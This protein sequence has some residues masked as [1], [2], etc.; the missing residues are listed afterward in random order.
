MFTSIDKVD[1][2][3]WIEAIESS[4]KLEP[5]PALLQASGGSVV[6][7]G[8]LSCHKFP[9]ESDNI[10]PLQSMSQIKLG[11]SKDSLQHV[12]VNY[13][14][15]WSV[16][17]STGLVQCMVDGKPETLVTVANCNKIRIQNPH[18][19]KDS[20][21]YYCLRL[22]TS[23]CIYILKAETPTDHYEWVLALEG[24]LRELNLSHIL[25][26]DK[27]R[28]SGYIAL[29]R[30][31]SLQETGVRG[32]QLVSPVSELEVLKDVYSDAMHL[33]SRAS[34]DGCE[35][36]D[37]LEGPPVPPR[38]SSAPPPPLPPRDPPPL[39]PK[40]GNSLQRTRTGSMASTLSNASSIGSV[41]FDEYVIMQPP[42]SLK[43][44]SPTHSLTHYTNTSSQNCS[45]PSP[46]TEGED[47]MPMKPAVG[48]IPL[49]SS[50]RK[51]PFSSPSQP[52]SI[53]GSGGRRGS[54][55]AKRCILLRS[56]SDSDSSSQPSLDATPPLPPRGSSPRHNSSGSTSSLSRNL[57]SS[58]NGRNLRERGIGGYSTA[59]FDKG[60]SSGKKSPLIPRSGSVV[61][62]T[63]TLFPR[64]KDIPGEVSVSDG[65]MVHEAKEVMNETLHSHAY[66]QAG[67][68][69]SVLSSDNALDIS[70]LS[71]SGSSTE[72][73]TSQVSVILCVIM[74]KYVILLSFI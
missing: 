21:E 27:C 1:T 69:S 37:Y 36:K 45:I 38:G 55:S 4:V 50:E 56:T 41:E 29:K 30:L 19:M 61:I 13:G 51:E 62:P 33:N 60:E 28:Q 42:T 10:N 23:L 58:M 53:P 14:K 3:R 15:L 8:F 74:M 66:S 72:D 31:M 48:P 5:S 26:G 22:E 59:F 44:T 11:D 7:T 46:I 57:N 54:S 24:I 32:S 73:I 12:P 18:S 64:P 63:S 16:I 6:H 47:Y 49:I 9:S 71:S 17:K 35:E 70:G 68:I 52:V 20:S 65:I 2:L 67:S 43:F 34:P 39:P 25:I 40:R